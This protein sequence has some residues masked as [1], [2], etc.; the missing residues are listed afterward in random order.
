MF[1][2]DLSAYRVV[3][4]SYEVVP[5]EDP[6]GDRPFLTKKGLLADGAEKDIIVETH[7][8]VGTHVEAPSHFIPGGKSLDDY[9]AR[10]YMGR[11]VL[12]PFLFPGDTP[13]ISAAD[14]EVG[15]GDILNSGDIV[16][17]RNDAP[18]PRSQMDKW[19][20]FTYDVAEWLVERKVRMLGAQGVRFGPDLQQFRRFEGHLMANEVMLIERP[21]HLRQL[22][23]RQSFL[24]ALPFLVRGFGSSW[25]RVVALE[26]I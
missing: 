14:I 3:D 24:I 19:P 7:N 5:N 25:A 21:G 9:P 18:L 6:F 17:C 10:H 1:N 23:K 8:H 26:E 13:E 11:C 16:I 2:I 20:Y 15:L 12:W 22:E 4:L